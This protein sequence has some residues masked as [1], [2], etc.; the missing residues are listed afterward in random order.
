MG[1]KPSTEASYDSLL[2]AFSELVHSTL[3]LPVLMQ[4]IIRSVQHLFHCEN[5]LALPGLTGFKIAAQQGSGFSQETLLNFTDLDSKALALTPYKNDSLKCPVL[6]QGHCVA[7]LLIKQPQWEIPESI[8]LRMVPMIGAA[9]NHAQTLA[10]TQ[11]LAATDQLTGL[12]NWAYFQHHLTLD[13]E[14]AKRYTYPV[15]LLLIDLDFFKTVNDTYGHP[16]GDQVLIELSQILLKLVRKTDTVSRYGGEEFAITLM[17]CSLENAKVIAEK[18]RNTIC[19]TAFLGKK[20]VKL[21]ISIGMAS[22][23]DDFD[24]AKPSET[25]MKETHA[26]EKDWLVFKADKA[27]YKAKQ[28]GRNRC[29]AYSDLT[30]KGAL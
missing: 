16:D 25:L 28:Q 11:Q 29:I 24:A 10:K 12:Y 7:W 1:T 20:N 19:K 21:S 4:F 27:L 23:P 17:K 15:T 3:S 13:I 18:I 14:R 22:F 30:P 26:Q 5:A 6:H 9:L 2:L 8:F